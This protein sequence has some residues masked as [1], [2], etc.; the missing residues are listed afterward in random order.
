MNQPYQAGDQSPFT[1]PNSS[2]HQGD[3]EENYRSGIANYLLGVV[4][5]WLLGNVLWVVP[6]ALHFY[7]GNLHLVLYSL[8]VLLQAA[9]G[10]LLL[11]AG[12]RSRSKE[13]KM[14]LVAVAVIILLLRI[15]LFLHHN[16]FWGG[17]GY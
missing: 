10:V 17:P 9:A 8:M 5:C 6:S 7:R 11:M 16:P 4:I 13:W 14:P 15:I 2:P 3:P 12:L 1:S